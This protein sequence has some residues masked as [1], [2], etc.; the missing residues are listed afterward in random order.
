MALIKKI[1]VPPE[2]IDIFLVD[3]YMESQ[4]NI[5]KHSILD[6]DANHDPLFSM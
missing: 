1:V 2:L 3:I 4:E 6:V 5:F